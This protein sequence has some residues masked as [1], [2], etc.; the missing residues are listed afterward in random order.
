M[1]R[2]DFL[3]KSIP[4]AMLPFFINGMKFQA[5]AATPMLKAIAEASAKNGRVFVFIQLSGG[6]DG[7]NTVIPTDQYSNLSNARANVLIQESKVL[8]LNGITGTGLHPAMTGL[9]N[10][11]NNGKLNIVQSVGY[12]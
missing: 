5:Y 8:T 3:K 9:R 2:K 12:P 11:F 10:M 6:N 4:A 7:L 1:K